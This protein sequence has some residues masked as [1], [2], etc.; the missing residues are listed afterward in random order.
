MNIINSDSKV[1]QMQTVERQKSLMNPMIPSS[2]LLYVDHTEIRAYKEPKNATYI[3]F[4]SMNI[5]N[6]RRKIFKA[7]S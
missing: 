3:P 2:T 5:A 7:I 1:L 4:I 6:I